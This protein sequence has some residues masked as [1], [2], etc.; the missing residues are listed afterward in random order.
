MHISL[1]RGARNT[2][3]DLYYIEEMDMDMRGN[4][5]EGKLAISAKA[6]EPSSSSHPLQS[7]HRYE[8]VSQETTGGFDTYPYAHTD[9]CNTISFSLGKENKN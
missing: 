4:G 1:F 2:A 8:R 9:K 5:Y 6:H 7:S 3:K